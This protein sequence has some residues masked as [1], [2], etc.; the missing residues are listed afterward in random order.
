MVA[1]N[2]N[3]KIALYQFVLGTFLMLTLPI[4]WI[5]IALNIGGLYAIGYGALLGTLMCASGRVLFARYLVGM[6]II[7]WALQLLLPVLNGSFHLV[8]CGSCFQHFLVK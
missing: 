6:S 5:L 4:A 3:G 1:V 8:C 7:D 2:A